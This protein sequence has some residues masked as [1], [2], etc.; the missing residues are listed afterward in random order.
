VILFEY[1]EIK[2]LVTDD[3]K[4]KLSGKNFEVIFL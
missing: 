3:L 1:K 4:G 2:I